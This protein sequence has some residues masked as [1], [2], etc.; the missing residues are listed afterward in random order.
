MRLAA[1]ALA[2]LVTLPAAAQQRWRPPA[3]LPGD[4]RQDRLA[5][6]AGDVF[7]FKGSPEMNEAARLIN[8]GV[9]RTQ[10][11]MVTR[12]LACIVPNGDSIVVTDGGFATSTVLVVSGRNTGCRGV[13]QN[14][15]IV[16]RQR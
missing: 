5:G 9:H 8:A 7:V 14:E 11:Q 10:P 15:D 12:L 1:F 2:L 3:D 13:V 16:R 4:P 6:P